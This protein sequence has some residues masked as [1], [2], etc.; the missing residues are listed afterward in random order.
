LPGRAAAGEGPGPIGVGPREA[1]EE[2]AEGAVEPL[3]G[4]DGGGGGGADTPVGDD[5]GAGD[6]ADAVP[7]A[8]SAGDLARESEDEAAVG[9]GRLGEDA[10]GD[11]PGSAVGQHHGTFLGPWGGEF[12][13]DG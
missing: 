8:V 1:T 4:R 7:V 11:D 3:A 12:I 5:R 9:G 2:P 10:G 13:G 6:V